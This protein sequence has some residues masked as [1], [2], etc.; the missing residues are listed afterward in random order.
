[1]FPGLGRSADQVAWNALHAAA[2]PVEVGPRHAEAPPA[3]DAVEVMR[4]F[5]T[6]RVCALADALRAG[7][8]AIAESHPPPTPADVPGSIAARVR[9]AAGETAPRHANTAR[10]LS[11]ASPS[12]LCSSPSS[13]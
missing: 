8:A 11:L 1:V 2:L 5:Q 9:T 3:R 13:H 10:R 6:A 12:T 4:E 7:E